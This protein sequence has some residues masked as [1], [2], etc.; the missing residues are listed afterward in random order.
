MIGT[1]AQQLGAVR[2]PQGPSGSVT[3]LLG[4]E[5]MIIDSQTTKVQGDEQI[6]KISN[7]SKPV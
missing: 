7:M 2:D 3:H 6:T 5:T 1:H 4:R